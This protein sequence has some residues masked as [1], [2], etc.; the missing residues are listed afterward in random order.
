MTIE[1]QDISTPAKDFLVPFPMQTQP[2]AATDLFSVS[3]D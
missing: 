3:M 2:Y 1:V